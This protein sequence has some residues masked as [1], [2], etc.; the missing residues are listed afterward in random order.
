MDS[1]TLSIIASIFVI[2][3]ESLGLLGYISKR[4]QGNNRF[5][6]NILNILS[7]KFYAYLLASAT[8][9]LLVLIWHLGFNPFG[10]HVTDKDFGKLLAAMLSFPVIVAFL[11]SLRLLFLNEKT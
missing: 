10:S 5:T 2:V 8:W 9:V 3:G 11:F 7:K 1:S 6:F 4:N